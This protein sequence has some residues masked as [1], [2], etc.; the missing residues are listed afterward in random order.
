MKWNSKGETIEHKVR[1]IAQGF[2]QVARIDYT[3]TFAPVAQMEGI[4]AILHISVQ[5][6]WLL[7]LFNVKVA[8]LYGD[9]EE[10]I[11]M[12]QLKDYEQ[13][14]HKDCLARLESSCT[15]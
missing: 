11:Y 8:F 14:G 15:A 3:D 6:N 7:H 4:C 12:R 9:L 5:C 10:E 13:T 1:L 2:M